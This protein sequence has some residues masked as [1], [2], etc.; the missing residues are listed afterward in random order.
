M[1]KIFLTVSILATISSCSFVKEVQSH[2]SVSHKDVSIENGSFTA[3]VTC[4]SLAKVVYSN[5]QKIK[6]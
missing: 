2:C 3:C 5:L 1:K 6:K 4:D